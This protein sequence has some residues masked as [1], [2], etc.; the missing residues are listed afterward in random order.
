MVGEPDAGNPHVR[1]D[2]GEQE[3]YLGNAP[4]LY[5]TGIAPL[6]NRFFD[7]LD[8]P[9]FCKYS[10][11][12]E[13]SGQRVQVTDRTSIFSI[14]PGPAKAAHFNKFNVLDLLLKW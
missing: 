8:L 3:T 14:K 12:G 7:F 13:L 4:A 11:S 9:G 1:F 6:K 2:E 10:C 5:S